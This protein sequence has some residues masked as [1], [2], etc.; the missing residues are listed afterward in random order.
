[1]PNQ[2]ANREKNDTGHG[3]GFVDEFLEEALNTSNIYEAQQGTNYDLWIS[4]RNLHT[5]ISINNT[6]CNRCMTLLFLPDSHHISILD[7]GA[8]TRVL[9][10]GWEV[11]SIH[12]SRRAN[13]V[14]FDNETAI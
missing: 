4:D 5:S 8:E 10:K 3:Y 12:N 13:A 11:L 9:G 7:G 6:L 1:M 14:G 2:Y